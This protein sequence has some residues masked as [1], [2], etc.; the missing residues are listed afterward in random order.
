MNR[1]EEIRKRKKMNKAEMARF[2]EMP[3]T[4]YMQYEAGERH[5]PVEVAFRIAPKLGVKWHRLYEKV[6]SS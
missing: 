6:E 3:R 5:L 4:T 2:L 1:L